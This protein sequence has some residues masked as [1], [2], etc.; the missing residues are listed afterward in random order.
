MMSPHKRKYFIN[1]Y[2]LVTCW[3]ELMMSTEVALYFKYIGL[4][5]IYYKCY[6]HLFLF[7]LFKCGY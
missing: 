1:Y 2:L 7:T 6:Y 3:N 4:N 5:K